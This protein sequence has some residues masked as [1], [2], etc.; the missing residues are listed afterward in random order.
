MNDPTISLKLYD[1]N[2]DFHEAI[3]V[4]R[5]PGL[6]WM[7]AQPYVVL[8]GRRFRRINDL[9]FE[10]RPNYGTQPYINY[11]EVAYE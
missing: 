8:H 4:A 10:R 1:N 9:R 11:E 6:G 7:G 3:G 2:G 5:S